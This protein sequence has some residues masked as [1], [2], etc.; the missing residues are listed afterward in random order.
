MY[1]GL[2]SPTCRLII[3]KP[4]LL[5][6]KNL[7]SLSSSSFQRNWRNETPPGGLTE[8]LVYSPES[9][10]LWPDTTL[11][12]FAQSDPQFVLPGNIGLPKLD[13][14]SDENKQSQSGQ[15][16]DQ[17]RNLGSRLKIDILEDKTMRERQAQTLYS[18]NDYI[19]YSQE[20]GY[21]C[22]NPVLIESFPPPD[23][24]DKCKF[25]L[26]EAPQLLRK[27]MGPL[28]PGVEAFHNPNNTVSVITMVQETKNDMSAWSSQMEEERE[29]L[30][31]QFV[32]LAKEFCGR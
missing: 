17:A 11:G 30:T 26:H 9:Q 27:E 22:S 18:A 28:F 13:E 7:R 31:C 12:V 32:G 20:E 29:G 14:I 21:V 8:I 5:C 15:V 4:F 2:T 24:M 23:S 1:I 10:I 6:R 3:R 16:E 25:E 19:Q